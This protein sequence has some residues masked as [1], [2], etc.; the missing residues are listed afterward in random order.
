MVW[1]VNGHDNDELRMCFMHDLL[2]MVS[3]NR[4]SSCVLRRII[5]CDGKRGVVMI[6]FANSGVLL[7]FVRE[8]A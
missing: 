3:Y 4:G 6:T 2:C 8:I 7:C 5:G 1:D